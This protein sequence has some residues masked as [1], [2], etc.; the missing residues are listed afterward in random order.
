MREIN[1]GFPP[2]GYNSSR[3]AGLGRRGFAFCALH[4]SARYQLDGILTVV[5]AKHCLEHLQEEKPE[6]VENESVEQVRRRWRLQVATGPTPLREWL[7]ADQ[8]ALERAG[9]GPSMPPASSHHSQTR[10]AP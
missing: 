3:L 4:F 6:G 7:G 8:V 9:V 1:G 10:A 5:D 2:L